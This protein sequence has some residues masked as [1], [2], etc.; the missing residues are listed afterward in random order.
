MAQL[1][2]EYLLISLN[3]FKEPVTNAFVMIYILVI[4]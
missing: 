2:L 4:I 1:A 3:Y